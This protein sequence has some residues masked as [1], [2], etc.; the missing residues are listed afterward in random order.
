MYTGDEG[1]DG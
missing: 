1:P